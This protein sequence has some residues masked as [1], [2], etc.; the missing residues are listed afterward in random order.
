MPRISEFFGVVISMYYDDHF[1]PHFH[2]RYGEYRM[3]V[4]IDTL[5]VMEGF[6]P[7]R[8]RGLVV[9]WGA[10]HQLELELNWRLGRLGLPFNKIAPLE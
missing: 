5:E 8:V 3:S 6:M 4:T 2:A 9:E 10:I 7:P 1:P